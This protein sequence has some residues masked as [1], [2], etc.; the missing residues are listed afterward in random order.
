M[1]V[2]NSRLPAP[3]MAP[4]GAFSRCLLNEEMSQCT[5]PVAMPSPLAWEEPPTLQVGRGRDA[6]AQGVGCIFEKD[7]LETQKELNT[8]Y[9]C[10]VQR[11][12]H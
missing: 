7:A 12:T 11:G 5:A 6:G 1:S 2:L 8:D 3:Y 4:W 10:S 9:T